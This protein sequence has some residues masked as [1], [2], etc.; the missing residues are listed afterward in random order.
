MK[1]CITTALPLITSDM[2]IF[3][4]EIKENVKYKRYSKAVKMLK[5]HVVEV[6]LR[7]EE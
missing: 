2:L 4:S 1:K 5:K 3:L 7:K 6:D